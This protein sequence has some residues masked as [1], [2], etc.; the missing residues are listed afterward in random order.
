M[1][2]VEGAYF[3]S[4]EGLEQKPYLHPYSKL[5]FLQAFKDD[6]GGGEM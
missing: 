4:E 6:G 3:K 5:V 1:M 2:K